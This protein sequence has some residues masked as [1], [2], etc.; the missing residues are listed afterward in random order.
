MV[1]PPDRVRSLLRQPFSYPFALRAQSS[2]WPARIE[3][4]VYRPAVLVR[5][6][7]NG[8]GSGP[9]NGSL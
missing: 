3:W 4:I 2:A 8:D 1:A 9:S 6:S 7:R 5:L